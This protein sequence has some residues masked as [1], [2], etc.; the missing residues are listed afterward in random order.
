MN[1]IVNALIIIIFVNVAAGV[2]FNKEENNEK[3]SL[4]LFS[5]SI[6]KRNHHQVNVWDFLPI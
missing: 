6:D 5:K 1:E 3:L 2:V 4:F